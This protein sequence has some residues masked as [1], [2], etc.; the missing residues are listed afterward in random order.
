MKANRAKTGLMI[1]GLAMGLS[2]CVSSSEDNIPFVSRFSSD[3]TNL[4]QPEKAEQGFS[5]FKRKGAE[6]GAAKS[7]DAQAEG[8]NPF[9]GLFKKKDAGKK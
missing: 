3:D 5:L 1:A 6:E 7:D 2:G 8:N 4:A 9:A